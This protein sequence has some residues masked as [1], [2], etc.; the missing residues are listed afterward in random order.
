MYVLRVCIDIPLAHTIILSLHNPF[1]PQALGMTNP[2]W[3]GFVEFTK[4]GEALG[5][6]DGPLELG[7][8]IFVN[9]K[10][11]SVIPVGLLFFG[12]ADSVLPINFG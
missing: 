1:G 9:P 11:F 12:F 8:V 2:N 10:E 6:L 7:M 4:S 5:W 3:V